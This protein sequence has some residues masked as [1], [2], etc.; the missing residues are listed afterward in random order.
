MSVKARVNA[1]QN[2]STSATG[3]FPT[4]YNTV[5]TNQKVAFGSLQIA[6][7]CWRDHTGGYQVG[8]TVDYAGKIYDYWA[9]ESHGWGGNGDG[10]YVDRIDNF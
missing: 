4:S 1:T 2:G 8:I 9:P 7:N 3:Y 5:T 6:S 10:M